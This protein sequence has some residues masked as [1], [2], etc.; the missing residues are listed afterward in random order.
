[1]KV[2]L[3]GIAFSFGS[4][5]WTDLINRFL[6]SIRFLN[7]LSDTPWVF[8]IIF[9][10]ILYELNSIYYATYS[11]FLYIRHVFLVENKAYLEN[12]SLVS[13]SVPTN[14]NI[15]GLFEVV[16]FT[17][18]R[19][20]DSSLSASLQRSIMTRRRFFSAKLRPVTYGL[21]GGS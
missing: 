20:V 8:Y 21:A 16:A 1:M 13:F 17:R 15:T 6:T 19:Q 14:A 11:T 18:T 5:R 2:S 4:S 12:A 9:F 10:L 7:W 3:P